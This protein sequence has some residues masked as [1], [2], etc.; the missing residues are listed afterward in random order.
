MPKVVSVHEYRLKPEVNPQDF[1]D[2][3]MKASQE[4][5]LQLPG[6]SEYFLLKGIRGDRLDQYTAVWIFESEES[7][8]ELW[9]PVGQPLDKIDYPVN[10]KIWEEQVLAPFLCQD[11]DQIRF[12][13]YREI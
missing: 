9:G 8:S 2:A 11:P 5:L 7:W 13:A 12:T 4:D 1:E 6:L 3:I 10:W